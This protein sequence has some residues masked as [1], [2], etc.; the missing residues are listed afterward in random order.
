VTSRWDVACFGFLVGGSW[1][2][3]G[4]RAAGGLGG[5]SPELPE[6]E[7]PEAKT[8]ALEDDDV[9]PGAAEGGGELPLA[10]PEVLC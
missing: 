7:T 2:G 3:G 6:G 9:A 1:E 8:G 4:A 5:S 10:L